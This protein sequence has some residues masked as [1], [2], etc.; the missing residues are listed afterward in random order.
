[1]RDIRS[2]DRCVYRESEQREL[3]NSGTKQRGRGRIR[4]SIDMRKPMTS[5]TRA[6]WTIS[7][8]SLQIA[9]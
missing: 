2:R 9:T 5:M 8:E 4:N 6:C 1:M 3:R 7:S